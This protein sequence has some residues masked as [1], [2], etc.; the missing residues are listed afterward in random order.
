MKQICR[1]FI[2]VSSTFLNTICFIMC[3]FQSQKVKLKFLTDYVIS[4]SHSMLSLQVNSC[5]PREQVFN[6]ITALPSF[7]PFR[8]FRRTTGLAF[9]G[10]EDTFHWPINLQHLWPLFNSVTN[11]ILVFFLILIVYY[12]CPLPFHHWFSSIMVF[13]EKSISFHFMNSMREK[14]WSTEWEKKNKK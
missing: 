5:T 12:I 7:W 1:Y 11:S 6:Y 3:S 14:K 8:D 13:G 4:G 2:T 10:T 9:H